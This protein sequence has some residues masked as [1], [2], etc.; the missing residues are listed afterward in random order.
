MFAA[1]AV[2]GELGIEFSRKAFKRIPFD[3]QFKLLGV[4]V[5]HY[6][7]KQVLRRGLITPPALCVEQS[8]GPVC[9]AGQRHWCSWHVRPE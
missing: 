8:R 2:L 4:Q 5:I 3:V 7:I 1:E 9:Q 6:E